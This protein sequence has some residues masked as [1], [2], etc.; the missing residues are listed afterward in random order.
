[1]EV[2]V[3]NVT[4]GAGPED[5]VLPPVFFSVLTQTITLRDL[6]TRTV[7]LQIEELL[8]SHEQSARYAQKLLDK[9]Y[10]D[11]RDIHHQSRY[12]KIA[13][14]VSNPVEVPRIDIKKES[15]RAIKAFEQ[16]RF[17]IFI[18]GK[19]LLDLDES[20]SYE[21]AVTVKFIRLMPLAGG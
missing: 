3:T 2:Q 8:D 16:Q 21:E 6:I 9:Q 13:L 5:A 17:M 19:Q 10:L 7:E 11:E 12:G 20:I 15:E 4:A 14:D 1:M 18:N